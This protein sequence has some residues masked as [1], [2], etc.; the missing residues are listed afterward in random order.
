MKHPST[1]ELYDYWDKQREAPRRPI[2]AQWNL[3]RSAI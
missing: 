1:R 2:A 3:V